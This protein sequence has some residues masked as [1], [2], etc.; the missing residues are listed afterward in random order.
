MKRKQYS[1]F[2]NGQIIESLLNG[3]KPRTVSEELD[4][5]VRTINDKWKKYIA[6]GHLDP[7]PRSGRPSKTSPRERTRIHRIANNNPWLSGKDIKHELGREDISDRTLRRV[8]V[9]H[10]G[11]YSRR[12]AKKPNLSERNRLKRL[13]FAN[14]YK[15]WTIDDWKK[16]LW[17][18]ESKFPLRFHG[19]SLVRRPVGKRFDDKYT[20]KTIKH[21][22]YVMI[23]G[24]FSWDKV[25]KIYRIKGTMDGD[26]YKRIL[27]YQ[28]FPSARAIF[29]ARPWCFQ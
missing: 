6:R 29:G 28:M 4:I 16:V 26:L 7:L 8:L 21:D 9:K 18:D 2:Q 14:L 17:S 3:K 24:C 10:F 23:W 13:Q 20:R 11:L 15:D 19:Q 22:K 12:A 1:S 25:G 5:P 27:I